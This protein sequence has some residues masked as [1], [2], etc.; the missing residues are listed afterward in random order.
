[1][2]SVNRF[3]DMV[4]KLRQQQ[5]FL[6]RQIAGRLEID[7]PMFSKIE[8]GE[9][10]AKR[11]QVVLLAKI[12]NAD[13]EELVTLWLADKVYE[14]VKDESTAIHALQVAEEEIN[15]GK[16]NHDEFRRT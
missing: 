11:E 3:G 14:V 7:T 5:N 2:K 12:L 13:Q 6:Q 15:Y 8:R 4:R 1:M 9:R 10:R 16:S